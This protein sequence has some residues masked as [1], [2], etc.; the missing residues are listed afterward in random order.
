MPHPTFT[1]YFRVMMGFAE[2]L[3]HNFQHWNIYH[4]YKKMTDNWIITHNVDCFL[5]INN[6]FVVFCNMIYDFISFATRKTCL[7]I[8]KY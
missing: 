8:L 6:S 5:K 7:L 1:G 4:T 2:A 3:T